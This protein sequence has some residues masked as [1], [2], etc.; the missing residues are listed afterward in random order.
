VIASDWR[1]SEE[2]DQPK[3]DSQIGELGLVEHDT[4]NLTVK[5]D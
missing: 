2:N 3:P 4:F 1:I 5:I